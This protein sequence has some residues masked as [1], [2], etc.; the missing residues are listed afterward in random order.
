MALAGLAVGSLSWLVAVSPVAGEV[1]VTPL[2]AT[3][4][5]SQA[6]VDTFGASW[7]Y[8]VAGVV[9]MTLA[10][11]G[12]Y[13]VADDDAAA[14]S[15]RVVVDSTPAL[16]GVTVTIETIAQGRARYGITGP[17]Y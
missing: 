16:R 8:R 1:S 10:E 6:A 17:N 9:T 13:I 7:P 5:V 2:V 15:I 4:S 14:A 12:I 11:G 3:M